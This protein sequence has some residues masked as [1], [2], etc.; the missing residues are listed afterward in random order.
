L[1]P[2]I[3]SVNRVDDFERASSALYIVS[4]QIPKNDS[5]RV[6]ILNDLGYRALEYLN[7]FINQNSSLELLRTD[8]LRNSLYLNLLA[9][10][11]C[12]QTS[13]ALDND[14]GTFMKDLNQSFLTTKQLLDAYLTL[15][16]RINF[17]SKKFEDS[18]KANMLPGETLKIYNSVIY[19]I[20]TDLDN[21]SVKKKNISFDIPQE[22]LGLLNLS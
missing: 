20:S 10:N 13:E 9:I 22:S 4:E 18:L 17:E 14:T 16:Q 15:S 2:E 21:I 1:S 12:V 11:E 6:R 3:T 19:R 7:Y 8:P 5:K